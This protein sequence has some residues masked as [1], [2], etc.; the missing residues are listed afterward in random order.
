MQ[1]HCAIYKGQSS[2]RL[3]LSF[4]IKVSVLFPPSRGVVVERADS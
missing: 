1:F 3:C 4:G 2:S